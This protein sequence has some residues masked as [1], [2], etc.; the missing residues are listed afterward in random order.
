MPNEQKVTRKL[1]AI[2]SADV[3]GYSILMADDEVATIQTLKEYRK[4]MSSCIQKRGGR[5]VDAVGD[6]LLAEFSSAVD[7]VECAV[8]VQKKL[9]KENARFAEERRLQFRIG[10]NIGDVVQDEERVYGSGIN[11]AARIERFAD[12]GGICISRNTY[13]QVKD[14]IDSGYEYLGEHEVKNIQEPV[15]VYKVILDSDVHVPLVEEQLELP[16]KPSIAVLPFTNMSANPSQE[17]FSDG[18]TEQ[19]ISGLC[20][21]SNLFVISRNS[22]FAYKGKSFSVRQIAQ[23][24]GVKYILEGSVQKTKDRVRITAQLIDAITDYH[25]WSESYD[26][27]LSDIFALQDEITLKLINAMQIKLTHGEQACLWDG[28]TKNIQ[29]FDKIM[30]GV[31]CFFRWNRDDNMRA[32]HFFEQALKLDGSSA[33]IFSFIGFTHINDIVFSW[34]DSPLESFVEAENNAQKA[35]SLN[36]SLDI[37][38]LLM[39]HI[40]LLKKEYDEAVF[41]AERA[42]ALNPNGADALCILGFFTSLAGE[43]Q[44]ATVLLKKAFRLNPVPPP[45]YYT[46]LGDVHRI[47]GQYEKAI[48]LL[49]KS[50]MLESESLFPHLILTACYISMNE[51]EKAQKT[52]KKILEI[53]SKFSLE[54]HKNIVPHK[55]QAELDKYIEALRRAG[56]P[57]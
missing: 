33:L 21:I 44:K 19:I 36:D 43:P 6:N 54:Y 29:A 38:H 4:I 26:R 57:E 9:K 46:Y 2:L 32:R 34:S 8:E 45:Y 50:I 16:D 30:R 13:D 24:L 41:E 23:E 53:D 42:V 7:A 27:S 31:E 1:R 17:Y 5:V 39:A 35:I 20:K 56:L 22:S 3:K 37:P 28:M 40:H 52:T 51:F 47:T 10:V 12:P 25:I 49:N 18:L 11:V 48:E 15:R 55:I 14:K